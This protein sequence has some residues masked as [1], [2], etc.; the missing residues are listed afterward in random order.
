MTTIATTFK[1]SLLILLAVLFV[2]Q[3]A[4]QA[5]NASQIM[6]RLRTKYKSVKTFSADFS[7]AGSS[8]YGGSQRLSGKLIM[9]GDRYRVETSQQTIVSNGKLTWVYTPSDR[10]VLVNNAKDDENAYSLNDFLYSNDY[11]PASVKATQS[12]GARHW[13][14]VVKPRSRDAQFRQAT[15]WLRDS[16]NLVTRIDVVDQND[17][18]MSFTLSNIK[19]NPR[20]SSATFAFRQP[21]GVEVVDLR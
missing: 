21:K 17:D 15:L 19:V 4:A 8:E 14:L 9:Q 3:S 12:G 5:Q 20:T 13:V 7:Q 18:R 1:R 2:G 16:D 6:Q 11:V 10:Q